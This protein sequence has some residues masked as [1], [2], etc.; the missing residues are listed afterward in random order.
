MQ[1]AGELLAA[2]HVELTV[3]VAEV[4]LNGL[5][6][7]E[8]R[9]GGLAHGAAAGEEQR[10][11]QLLRCQVVERR[12]VAAPRGLAGRRELAARPLGP[13]RR[14]EVVERRE[15]RAQ[16]VAGVAPTARPPE[17]RTVGEAR[18]RLLEA[19]GRA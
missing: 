3:R 4:V 9:R 14:A 12:R 17:Q 2:A 16:L 1:G 8:E 10:D 11:L 18:A 5:R 15:G 19:I 13:R 6:A 7:Q